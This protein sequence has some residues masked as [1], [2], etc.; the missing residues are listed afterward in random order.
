[1]LVETIEKIISAKVGNKEFM[2]HRWDSGEWNAQIGNN[3]PYV[4]LGEIEGEFQGEGDTPE[5]A[6]SDLLSKVL[7]SA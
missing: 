6:A 4:R 7:A 5:T 1:M 3:N 2:L